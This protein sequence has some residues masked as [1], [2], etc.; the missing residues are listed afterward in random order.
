MCLFVGVTLAK[1]DTYK[2]YSGT[3][4]EG[5]YLV[6]YTSSEGYNVM[7]AKISDNRFEKVLLRASDDIIT[8]DQTNLVWHIAKSGNYWTIYSVSEEKYAASTTSDNQAQLLEIGT[9]NK[10]LWTVSGSSTYDFVNKYNSKYLRNNKSYG[11]ACYSNSTGRA[12]TLF[13]KVDP[14]TIT[15]AK[16]ATYCSTNAL[17]FSTTGVTVYKAKVDGDVVKLTAI[18]DG[19]VPANTGVILYKDVDAS[20]TVYVPVTT[21]DATITD[22]E[23]VGTTAKTA[24]SQ[25]ADGK[26]NYIMQKSGDDIVFSIAKSE[27]TV[28][29]PANRAY[30]STPSV[31]PSRL[32][33]TFT[34]ETAGTGDA[35]RLMDN[36]KGIMDNIFN[37]NGQRI[38]GLKK[39]LYIKNGKKVLV[40]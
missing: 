2:K 26:T 10:S 19:I 18:E 35:S 5:D 36:G 38:W 7:K 37:L 16:Y 34:D 22:N 24:V 40:T 25:T 23:L 15:D 20:T 31:A 14:V 12:L 6:T 39:G 21:T 8:T 3:L 29:M 4:T 33:V 30:L 13:R 32:S 27:G 1:A 11:F 28:Y 9:N 17:N